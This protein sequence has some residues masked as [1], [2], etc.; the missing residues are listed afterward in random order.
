[1]VGSYVSPH[2]CIGIGRESNME[3]WKSKVFF[4]PPTQFLT[5]LWIPDL[6][7]VFTFIALLQYLI[8][9]LK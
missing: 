4:R 5:I 7:A 8:K 1:M 2:K 6:C 9:V 3:F